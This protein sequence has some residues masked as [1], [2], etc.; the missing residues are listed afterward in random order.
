[1]PCSDVGRELAVTLLRVKLRSHESSDRALN[2]GGPLNTSRNV[3]DFL[4]AES[5]RVRMFDANRISLRGFM[6]AVNTRNDR[7]YLID[8]F[9]RSKAS[10]VERASFALLRL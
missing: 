8:A 9:L 10:V 6:R 1:V 3:L 7:F 5:R 4:I 2:R